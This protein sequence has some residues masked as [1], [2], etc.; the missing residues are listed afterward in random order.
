M[1]CVGCPTT[2]TSYSDH[3]TETFISNITFNRLAA[4]FLPAI[5]S[6]R[7]IYECIY[8]ISYFLSLSGL[9]GHILVGNEFNHV[10]SHHLLLLKPKVKC[11]LHG[12]CGQTNA[13][14]LKTFPLSLLLFVPYMQVSCWFPSRICLV[15][16]H[17][18][19]G[20]GQDGTAART[21]LQSHH[22]AQP[23]Q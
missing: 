15:S 1:L 10:Q 7:F 2:S 9:S 12:F 19:V 17:Q 6:F 14:K 20:G 3:S 13:S 16:L 21:H 22:D 23:A 11:I 5:K 18:S 4:V 8:C